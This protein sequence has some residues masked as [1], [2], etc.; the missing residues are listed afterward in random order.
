MAL[1]GCTNPSKACIP[2]YKIADPNAALCSDPA[3]MVHIPLGGVTR[4]AYGVLSPTAVYLSNLQASATTR[5]MM[6]QPSTV[7]MTG[8]NGP[9][10]SGKVAVVRSIGNAQGS[11]LVSD[12]PSVFSG[13]CLPNVVMSLSSETF[14]SAGGQN[15]NG[16]T[17][18]VK[19][20]GP[21]QTTRA[22]WFAASAPRPSAGAHARIMNSSVVGLN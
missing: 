17:L 18:D 14:N 4:S 5:A 19:T 1:T 6:G 2:Q 8:T 10:G 13:F 21:P 3:A 16:Y 15:V 9:N 20:Q 22:D 11:V 12:D 7:T